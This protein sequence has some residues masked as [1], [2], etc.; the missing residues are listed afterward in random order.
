MEN[1]FDSWAHELFNAALAFHE[2]RG[3]FFPSL[4]TFHDRKFDKAIS[5]VQFQED[6]QTHGQAIAALDVDAVGDG[7]SESNL[8][9]FGACTHNQCFIATVYQL[10]FPRTTSN[11]WKKIA[12]RS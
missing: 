9:K 5:L 4:D 2:Y 1:L 6:I 12:D 8:E 3:E 10:G 11:D 7:L